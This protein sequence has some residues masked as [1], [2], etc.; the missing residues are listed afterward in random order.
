MKVQMQTYVAFIVPHESE[1]QKGI[2][3]PFAVESRNLQDL[4]IPLEACAFYFYDAPTGLTPRES[5]HEKSNAS[6]EYLLAHETLTRHEIKVLLAGDDYPALR[7]RM[8]WDAR[9]EDYELF[10]ITR[11]NSVQPVTENHIVINS[12]RQQVYP[13]K[14][15]GH[16]SVDPEHLASL[17]NPVLQKDILVPS[18]PDIRRRSAGGNAPRKP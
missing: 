8:Q 11:N 10:I 5:L 7:G 16:G 4:D 1:P 3:V 2:A 6:K 15:E 13:L 9:V 12:L 17:F 14:P 18:L